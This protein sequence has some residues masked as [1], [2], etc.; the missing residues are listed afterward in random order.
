MYIYDNI[1]HNSS[2]NEKVFRQIHR[3]IQNTHVMFKNL[4]QK[5]CHL[6]DNVRNMVKPDKTKTTIKYGACALHAGWL[7]VQ[8][9]IGI[10]NTY[11]NST[12]TVVSES[13]SLLLCTLLKL[14][15]IKSVN[16]FFSLTSLYVHSLSSIFMLAFKYL[17][18]LRLETEPRYH[19]GA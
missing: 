6:W 16:C 2:Q 12:T 3:E 19:Y 11:C 14:P 7:R 1:P 15:K 9:I 13:V 18:I 5:P 4:F 10:C 8:H 17:W